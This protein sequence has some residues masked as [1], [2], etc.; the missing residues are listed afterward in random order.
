ML[1]RTA[2]Y[3]RY[4]ADDVHPFRA[5]YV[6]WWTPVIDAELVKIMASSEAG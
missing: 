1:Y 6:D 5:G 4:M 2:Q 3:R